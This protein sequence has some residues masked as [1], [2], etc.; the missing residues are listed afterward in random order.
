MPVRE[1]DEYRP[2][3]GEARTMKEPEWLWAARQ[4]RETIQDAGRIFVVQG[5]MGWMYRGDIAEA[6]KALADLPR[7]KLRQVSAAATALASL[8]DQMARETR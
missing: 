3:R 4:F 6:R 7:D 5:A 8:A 2:E 1:Y